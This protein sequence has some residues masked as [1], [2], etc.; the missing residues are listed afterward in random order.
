MVVDGFFAH[1]EPGRRP[2]LAAGPALLPLGR[3]AR[4][5]GGREPALVVA[6]AER[7]AGVAA[8]GGEPATDVPGAFRGFD[9]TI[10]TADFGV[11]QL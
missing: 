4:V 5:G 1:E 2:V 9:V 3:L 6:D 7:P 11:R 10:V 8:V